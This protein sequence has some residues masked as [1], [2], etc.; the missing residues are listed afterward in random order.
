MS[1]YYTTQ[2]SEVSLE[3][4]AACARREFNLRQRV[5]PRWVQEGR[6]TAEKAQHEIRVME[7]IYYTLFRLKELQEA[8]EEMKA[9]EEKRQQK[10]KLES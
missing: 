7:S 4:M 5:Y 8:S 9:L 10:L 6:M 1:E 2:D 3:Q